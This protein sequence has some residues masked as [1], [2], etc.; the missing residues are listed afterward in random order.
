MH[1]PIDLIQAYLTSAN[2]NGNY[3]DPNASACVIIVEGH[4][5][6]YARWYDDK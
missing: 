3:C 6:R 1:T 5:C 4:R 2:A